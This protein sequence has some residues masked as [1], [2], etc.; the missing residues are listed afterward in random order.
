MGLG[1]PFSRAGFWPDGGASPTLRQT[2][3]IRTRQLLTLEN[4]L[5]ASRTPLAILAERARATPHEPWLFHREGWD[6][7]W[8]S[9]S[10][11]ADQVARS[12]AVLRDAVAGG[13]SVGY[14]AR[15]HPDAIACG[16]AIRAAGLIAMPLRGDR[17]AASRPGCDA[18]A[19]VEG[20]PE[21]EIAPDPERIALPPALSPLERTKPQPLELDPGAAAGAVRLPDLGELAPGVSLRAAERLDDQLRPATRRTIVCASPQLDQAAAQLLEAWTLVRGAAWVLEPDSASFVETAL[22]ARPTLVWGLPGEIEQLAARLGTRKRRRQ[23]RI[24]A[25]VVAGSDEG[26][27]GAGGGRVDRRPW[28][29]LGA[30]VL[31]LGKDP[32]KA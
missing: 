20:A 13:S 5:L 28:N 24:S 29:E 31:A 27:E 21:E 19:E 6:W 4:Q 7:R 3:A 2:S 9:W 32:L 25:V 23:S 8:R 12:V 16:L 30:Q 10:R 15:Q 11:V 14:E 1:P 22:W 17:R 26:D 18:W